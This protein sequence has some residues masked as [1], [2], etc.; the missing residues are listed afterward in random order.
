[1]FTFNRCGF[2]SA[3]GWSR[4]AML[5]TGLL[6]PVFTL[7]PAAHAWLGGFESADG[8]QPFLNM[9][10]NYNAGQYGANSGYMA[11][12]PAAITPNSGLWTA[13]QGGFSS[14]GGISY[15]T[16][17]QNLDRTWIN[18]NMT[19]GSTNDQCLMLTTGH[20]GWSGPALKYR[21]N[22]DAQDLGG[23]A[24]SMTG[25][26]IVKLSF[27]ARGQLDVQDGSGNQIYGYLGNTID[28]QDASGN[29]GFKLGLT[30]RPTGDKITFWDGS[31]M[32]ETSIVGSGGYY[33]RWDITLDLANQTV[34]ASYFE[35]NTS[36]NNI[37]ATNVPMMQSMAN[38]SMLTFLTTPGTFNAKNSSVDDF[39][40]RA[41][42]APGS[43]GLLALAGLAAARRR[44]A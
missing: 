27:W 16:G 29:S 37:L 41:T 26:Q 10:Q 32:F 15:V 12:S 18:S 39:T 35:F 22:V 8:Y 6:A 5:T 34:S 38:F 1:M 23:V 44:R 9:V 13:L 43:V 40:F 19:M 2:A 7:T 42:P 11:M 36:T 31:N 14:G 24:P 33:D 20:E 3:K 17:H 4:C 28:F 21:Y 25:G 30:N